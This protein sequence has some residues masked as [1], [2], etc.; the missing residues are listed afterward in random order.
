MSINHRSVLHVFS[1]V[2]SIFDRYSSTALLDRKGIVQYNENR[3]CGYGG[4]GRRGG[5]RSRWETVQVR[6]LLAADYIRRPSIFFRCVIEVSTGKN[7]CVLYISL[8]YYNCHYT[9]RCQILLKR[10]SVSKSLYFDFVNLKSSGY[11][12]S[13]DRQ[14]QEDRRKSKS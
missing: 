13:D 5:F 2:F 3:V 4:I 6:V 11:N 7:S 12:F 10:C 14:Q 8:L 1:V 9:E